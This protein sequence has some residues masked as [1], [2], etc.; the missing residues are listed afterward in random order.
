MLPY[1]LW[2][3]VTINLGNYHTFGA[4]DSCRVAEGRVPHHDSLAATVLLQSS[5]V[6]ARHASPLAVRHSLHS[7]HSSYPSVS[8]QDWVE[9]CPIL[10]C[11]LILDSGTRKLFALKKIL[12]D[13]FRI[14]L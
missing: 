4:R 14:L 9:L 12:L 10:Q 3:T 13:R 8:Y 6:E 2:P 1:F 7:T 11:K 5:I